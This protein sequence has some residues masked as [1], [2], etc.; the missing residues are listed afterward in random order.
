[1]HDT[2]TQRLRQ[3]N[4]D[5]DDCGIGVTAPGPAPTASWPLA[6]LGHRAVLV[7]EDLGALRFG[8]ERGL[9]G[10]GGCLARVLLKR[11]QRGVG[12]RL[13]L[14][15]GIPELDEVL[16]KPLDPH[17]GPGRVILERRNQVLDPPQLLPQLGRRSSLGRELGREPLA[18]SESVGK[19]RLCSGDLV[20]RILKVEACVTLSS[21]QGLGVL[22]RGRPGGL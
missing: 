6:R 20:P 4:R 3:R 17:L 13:G 22:H 12:P 14:A 2:E 1:M 7:S 21:Q 10:I 8:L 5:F 11:Q 15:G 16:L 18:L 19:G 9:L